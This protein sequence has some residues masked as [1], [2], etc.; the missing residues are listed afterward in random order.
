VR[1]H[2]AYHTLMKT[3]I[4]E[5]H[6]RLALDRPAAR[7]PRGPRRA[8]LP[9]HAGRGRPRL[10]DHHDLRRRARRCA[11][12]PALAAQ[13]VPKITARVYD[14]RNV[15]DGAEAGLTIGMA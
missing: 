11:C 6:A 15:P 10:P 9:A 12:T 13:W 4:E 3:A 5:W 1:F 7:R 14:P 8:L 2:P